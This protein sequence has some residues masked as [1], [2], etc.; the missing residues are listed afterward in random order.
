MRLDDVG[1]YMQHY[2]KRFLVIVAGAMA[3]ACVL[4]ICVDL[5]TAN[6]SVDYFAVHHPTILKTENPWILAI[7]WGIAATWWCGAIAGIIVAFINHCR[8]VPLAPRRIFKWV[9]IACFLIWLIMITIVFIV[10]AIAGNIPEEVRRPTFEY[11]R[12]IVA[13]AFA[14]QYEYAFGGMATLIIAIMTWRVKA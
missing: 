5:V 9:I 6:V 12:R 10:I 8:S 2:A 1:M 11:D 4:G 14:H 13:V 3:L 7:I